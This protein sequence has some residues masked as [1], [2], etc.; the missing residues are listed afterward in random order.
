MAKSTKNKLTLQF[1]GFADFAERLDAL[2]GDLKETTEKALKESHAYVTPKLVAAM[3]KHNQTGETVGSIIIHAP[4]EWVGATAEIKVGF[5]IDKGGMPSIF[6]MYGT[7]RH[8]PNHSGTDADEELYNAIYG[9]DTK[10]EVAKI[11]KGIFDAAIKKK[12]EG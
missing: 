10:K 5:E 1:S 3:E 7:P 2:G 4:V 12:M 6:L 9:K 8:E 11:Q